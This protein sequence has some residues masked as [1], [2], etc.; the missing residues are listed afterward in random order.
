MLPAVEVSENSIV[1]AKTALFWVHAVDSRGLDFIVL[2]SGPAD[3]SLTA[4]NVISSA[5]L[6]VSRFQSA[7]SVA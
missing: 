2:S 5:L 3:Y 7:N 4:L 6:L 1:C